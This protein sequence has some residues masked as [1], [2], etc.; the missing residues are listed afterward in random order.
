MTYKKLLDAFWTE[1]LKIVY[2]EKNGEKRQNASRNLDLNAFWLAFMLYIP[3]SLF[4]S[5]YSNGSLK[6]DFQSIKFTLDYYFIHMES[7][8]RFRLAGYVILDDYLHKE[9]L[10]IAPFLYYLFSQVIQEEEKES[11]YQCML[12][13]PFWGK[14]HFY[15]NPEDIEYFAQFF[16]ISKFQHPAIVLKKDDFQE[17]FFYFCSKY[18]FT[19]FLFM[20]ELSNFYLNSETGFTILSNKTKGVL[21]RVFPSI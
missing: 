15:D 5:I 7:E 21:Q 3:E 11:F 9:T 16:Q 14:I 19:D 12:L 4:S 2:K 8:E 1:Y 20:N 10:A 18:H 17:T 13:Y 6:D